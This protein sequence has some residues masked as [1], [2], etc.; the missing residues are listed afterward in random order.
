M[1]VPVSGKLYGDQERDNLIQCA[2]ELLNGVQSEHWTIEFERKFEQYLGVKDA[3]FCNSGSSANLLAMS[4]LTAP[5]LGDRRLKPGDEVI[6]TALN[7]PTTVNP[8]LQVGA[9]PVFVDVM[10]PEYVANHQVVMDAITTKTRAIILAHTLGYPVKLHELYQLC[11]EWGI[12]LIEDCCDALGSEINGCK[13]GTIGDLA[14]F[15]FY[16]A[17]QIS[18][19]EGGMVVTSNPLLAKLVRSFRDWG[20]DCWC[21]PGHDNT[22]FKRFDGP[23]DHKYTYSHIGYNLK[24]TNMAAAIGC[25]QMDRLQI[26]INLRKLNYLHLWNQLFTF[27]RIEDYNKFNTMNNYFTSPPWYATSPF[28]F[29]LLCKPPVRR[30]HLCRFL[31]SWGVHNRPIFGGNL[32]RQPAYE[33]INYRIHGELTNTNNIHDTAFWI[34]CWPGLSIEQLDYAANKIAEYCEGL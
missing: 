9:V 10:I 26:F 11:Q 16:P 32:L 31:D 15:S 24:G 8:I 13:R 33:G 5:E 3:M 28:G 22:C 6:T 19:E 7:F 30:N 18:T 21:E 2:N 27:S 12:W 34:G 25:A 14:T 1:I 29:P 23:Y 17:H 4:A 20:R